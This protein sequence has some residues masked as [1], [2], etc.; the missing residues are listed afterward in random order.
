[1]RTEKQIAASRL[2]GRKSSGAATSEGKA[3]IVAANLKS[4]VYA[5]SEI[6]PWEEAESLDRLEAE[7]YDHHRPASPEAR[8]LLDDLILCEWTLRRLHRAD[9]NLWEFSAREA[10]RPDPDYAPA[11]S[12]KS[13]DKT[14]SR[15]QYRLN[16]TRLAIHRTLKDL[17][18]LEASEAV[19]PRTC[20]NASAPTLGNLSPTPDPRPPAPEQALASLRNSP[21]GPRASPQPPPV[22]RNN[23]HTRS[24]TLSRTEL[25]SC[26]AAVSGSI[27]RRTVP[28][29]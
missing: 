14:F 8:L 19:L 20:P 25:Y 6:L 21:S 9:S 29:F 4:G 3:R 27:P 12:F 16:G 18:N 5:E 26:L 13:S 24:R 11:Q 1:M 15:L 22:S 2:N 17:R 7:Y 28:G 10:Y 23:P